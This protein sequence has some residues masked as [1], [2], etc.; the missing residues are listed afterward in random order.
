MR[1]VVKR[2]LEDEESIEE[3]GETLKWVNVDKDEDNAHVGT[4]EGTKEEAPIELPQFTATVKKSLRDGE[5]AVVWN[6]VS[7]LRGKCP[8]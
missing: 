8:K 4:K 7:E 3:D 2:K 6:M 5:S 1:S